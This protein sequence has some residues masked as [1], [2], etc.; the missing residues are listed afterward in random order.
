MHKK[1]SDVGKSKGT[2]TMADQSDVQISLAL[3]CRARLPNA[4]ARNSNFSV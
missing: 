3:E 4:G 2:G 1:C